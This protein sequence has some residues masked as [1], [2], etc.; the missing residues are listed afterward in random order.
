MAGIIQLPWRDVTEATRVSLAVEFI[1]Y[2]I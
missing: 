2:L 1:F